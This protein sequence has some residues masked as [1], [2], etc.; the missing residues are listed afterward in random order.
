MIRSLEEVVT[1]C[2]GKK[3]SESFTEEMAFEL[4]QYL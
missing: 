1:F 4:A 2:C 3:N